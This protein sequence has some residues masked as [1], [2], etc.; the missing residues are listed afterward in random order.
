MPGRLVPGNVVPGNEVPGRVVQ[1]DWGFSGPLR[2]AAGLN[3]FWLQ[4]ALAKT[5]TTNPSQS[6]H[7]TLVRH[8]ATDN[9][10]LFD[11]ITN[12][13]QFRKI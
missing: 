10:D 9:D 8:F 11:C 6:A 2:D 4:P 1:F 3:R 12:E 7:S 13:F 5:K